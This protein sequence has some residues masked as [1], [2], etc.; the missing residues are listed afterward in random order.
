MDPIRT[1]GATTSAEDGRRLL[2]M[3]SA[4]TGVFEHYFG[5]PSTGNLATA[6]SM[7]RPME[8]MFTERQRLWVDTIRSILEFVVDWAARAPNGML[9]TGSKIEVDDEG[10]ETVILAIDPGTQEPIDRTVEVSF[11]PLLEKS[12]KDR[13]L[14]VV[15]A[16]TLDGKTDAG[17]IPDKRY[18]TQLILQAL[19]EEDVDSILDVLYPKD[20]D[21]N[22]QPTAEPSTESRMLEAVKDLRE[23]VVRFVLA[24]AAD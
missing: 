14:A 22:A 6:T 11:P 24:R 3:V 1:G 4:A 17:T 10:E 20:Q 15:S 18:Q 23:A 9:H 13:L 7:E 12:V 21:P 16:V 2:L 5:D 8:M 19:G